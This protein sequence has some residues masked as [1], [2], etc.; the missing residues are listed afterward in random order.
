M[1]NSSKRSLL[2]AGRDAFDRA[3]P[4]GAEADAALAGFRQA[5]GELERQVRRG[6]LTLKVARERAGEAASR[7]RET[8]SRQA[9]G[10][11]PAPRAFLDR[12]IEA[13][14]AR[15]KA[16]EALSIEG[17]QRETNRLLRLNLTEQQL[18]SR[19]AEFEGKAFVRPIS[20]GS[21]A[22][23]LDGLLAFD[24]QAADSGDEVAREWG[25]RQ[26]EGLRN[27]VLNDDDVRKIDLACDRPDRVNLRLVDAY[28][29]SIRGRGDDALE[30]FVD[31][32]VAD[33]DANACVAAFVLARLEPEG[34]RHRWV[35][36]VLA[37]LVAFPDAALAAL[38]PLEA[39]ARA[40]EAEA[41]RAQAQFAIARAE[42]EVRLEGV[43]PPTEADLERDRQVRRKPL[44]APGEPIGLALDRRGAIEVD[45]YDHSIAVEA[46]SAG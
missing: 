9:E 44:A 17:L 24:R 31:R 14:D 38:R 8:L 42:A 46:G 15:S 1:L 28:V 34:P 20:G 4:F 6:D 30:A 25:R 3:S 37:A 36:Q 39:E 22:P 21:P 43:E 19:A 12:L 18:G 45:E 13:A 27:R 7:L 10:Y 41:A 26:L 5:R 40:T 33:R 16:R 32:A 35:R 23:S 2:K 11:S 29:E